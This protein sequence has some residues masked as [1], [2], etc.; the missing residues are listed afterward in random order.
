[1]YI[2]TICTNVYIK[3]K[4]AVYAIGLSGHDQTTFL[5]CIHYDVNI[6]NFHIKGN[7]IAISWLD[8]FQK[9]GYSFGSK[10]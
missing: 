4:Y 8:Q 9:A 5:K 7:V 2:H 1:M 6:L 10:L 3:I